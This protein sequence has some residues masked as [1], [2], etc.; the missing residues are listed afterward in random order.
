MTTWTRRVALGLVLIAAGGC[1]VSTGGDFPDS[2]A[3][4]DGGTTGSGARGGSGG[5]SGSSGSG[6]NGG[7]A[8]N[9]TDSGVGGT[10][11]S[12]FEGPTCNEEEADAIDACLECV[13]Q[14]CC[15]E[16]L[17]CDDE[18]CYNEWIGVTTC[19]QDL[20]EPGQSEYEECVSTSAESQDEMIIQSNTID[21]FACITQ[22]VENDAG[23]PS[24]RCGL[25]CLGV[26]VLF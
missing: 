17:G 22:E 26:E 9:Q 8:G 16:W 24:M 20:D 10:G 1:E 12:D 18:G 3:G 25:P 14:E 6:G 23:V 11:G 4:A 15:T 13:K 5:S 7:S 2:G 21:L 19:M